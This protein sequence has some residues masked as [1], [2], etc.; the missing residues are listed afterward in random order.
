MGQRALGHRA[1]S[2]FGNGAVAFERGFRH[3]QHVDF[4]GVGVGDKAPIKPGRT[5]GNCGNRLR[6]PTAGER[7]GKGQPLATTEQFVADFFSKYF[8]VFHGARS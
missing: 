3:T 8:E 2:C 6:H 4:G 7:L 5:A 1:G